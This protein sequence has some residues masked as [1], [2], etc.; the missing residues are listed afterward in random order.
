MP[1][2]DTDPLDPPRSQ[3][4][5]QGPVD[6]PAAE[7]IA[8]DVDV[9]PLEEAARGMGRGANDRALDAVKEAGDS[10][11]SVPHDVD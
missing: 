11:G 1:R 4:H 2:R 9:R 3:Q 10:D 6:D 5:P 7:E 8:G